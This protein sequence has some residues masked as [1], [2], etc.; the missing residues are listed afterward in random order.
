M[1]VAK[2]RQHLSQAGKEEGFASP[3]F[4][5]CQRRAL[6]MQQLML[7]SQGGDCCKQQ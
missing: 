7:E 6:V 5:G 4:A 3:V 1:E 2:L